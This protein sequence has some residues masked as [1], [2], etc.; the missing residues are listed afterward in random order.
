MTSVAITMVVAGLITL[1]QGIYLTM[2]SNIGSCVVSIIAGVTGSANAKR[3]SYIHLL[4]N[5]T[6]VIIFLLIGQALKLF[7]SGAMSFGTIF[8]GLFPGAPQ[9]QLAMFHTVF[10]VV[11]VILILPFTNLLVAFVTKLVPDDRE[12]KGLITTFYIDDNLL[13]TPPIAVQQVKKEIIGMAGLAMR[14]FEAAIDMVLT[15]D[16]SGM[17]EFEAVENTLD[18]MKSD[19]THYVSK[20]L[21]AQLS[22]DDG[23]YLSGALKSITD[24]ERAGDYAEDIVRFGLAVMKDGERFSDSALAEIRH[25]ADLVGKLFG[26]VVEAYDDEDEELV[27]EAGITQ[28]TISDQASQMT[29]NHVQRISEGRC[30]PSAGMNYLALVTDIERIGNHFYN[31]A[32]TVR[33]Y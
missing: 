4:F 9:I 11:A 7:T 1:D 33:G 26:Q 30:S 6:G 15:S 3:A 32:R 22:S 13:A 14:N 24:I 5:V 23:E 20:L 12:R 28:L 19:L 10:N 17:E 21:S 16:Y 8:E 25:L 2:G 18:N 31:M 29:A 27:Y